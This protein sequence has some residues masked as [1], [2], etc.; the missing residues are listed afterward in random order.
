MRSAEQRCPAE[1]KA[2]M[3]TSSTTCSFSA[4]VSQNIALSPPVSAISGAIGAI[5]RRQRA[6]DDARHLRRAGEGDAATARIA[7]QLAAHP[8]VAGQQVER[9]DRQARGVEQL[10]GFDAR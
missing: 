9:L 4:V 5:L 1:R 3:I 7:R 10:H 2:D 8:A 6:I